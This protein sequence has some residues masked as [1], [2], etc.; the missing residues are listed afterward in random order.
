LVSSPEVF[1]YCT[2][3]E[4]SENDN[5]PKQLCLLCL[6][7]LNK[8]YSFKQVVLKSHEVLQQ[9][10]YD[11]G[12]VK[13]ENEIVD[14]ETTTIPEGVSL[15]DLEVVTDANIILTADENLQQYSIIKKDENKLN[16]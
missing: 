10:V 7:L 16:P 12:K 14:C 9:H 4:I 2:S 1:K 11:E 15:Q 6:E 5:L 13:I 3:L 8:F